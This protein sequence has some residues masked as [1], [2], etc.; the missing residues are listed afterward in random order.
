MT[1]VIILIGSIIACIAVGFGN[2]VWGDNKKN[3]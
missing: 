3:K 2:K 1:A